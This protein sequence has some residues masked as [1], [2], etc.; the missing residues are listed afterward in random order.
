MRIVVGNL[1]VLITAEDLRQLFVPYGGVEH[2]QILA[3]QATGQAQGFLEMPDAT[4]A[5]TAMEGLQGTRLH[6]QTLTI[7]AARWQW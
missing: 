1:T 3:A 7:Q 5:Q 2:V 6:G 4:A